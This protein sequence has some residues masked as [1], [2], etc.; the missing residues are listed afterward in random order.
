M[1]IDYSRKGKVVVNMEDY[2]DSVLEDA[3]E[4]ISEESITPAANHLFEVSDKPSLLDET[5][6]DFFTV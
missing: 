1:T 4:D 2:V 5:R 3:P 6:S